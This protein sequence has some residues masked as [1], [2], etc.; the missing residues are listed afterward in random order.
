M[1][2]T[3]TISRKLVAQLERLKFDRYLEQLLD[4]TAVTTVARLQNAGLL[5]ASH[6]GNFEY[7]L[8]PYGKAILKARKAERKLK[9]RLFKPNKK[10]PKI[11]KGLW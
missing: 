5:R 10:Q 4:D 6:T 7:Y 8:T 9:E 1:K 2:V 11:K 3:I